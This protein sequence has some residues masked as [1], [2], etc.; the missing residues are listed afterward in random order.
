MHKLALMTSGLVQTAYIFQY[1]GVIIV[2][3]GLA[4][5]ATTATSK[6]YQKSLGNRHIKLIEKT[7]LAADKSL[8]LVELGDNYYFLYVDRHGIKKLD[9]IDKSSL[10]LDTSGQ[11]EKKSPTFGAIFKGK[12]YETTPDNDQ[13]K[14]HQ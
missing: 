2:V 6:L 14:L 3:I 8:W 7:N 4:Y 10:P 12:M 13:E 5:L 9:V 11:I 1:I